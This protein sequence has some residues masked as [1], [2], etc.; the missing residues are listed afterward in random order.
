M[1]NG[2]YDKNKKPE[3]QKKAATIVS[4]I[5]KFNGLSHSATRKIL[6]YIKDGD[7]MILK[8]YKYDKELQQIEL[9]SKLILR[10]VLSVY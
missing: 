5:I 10:E 7:L 8:A 3:T 2:F 1:K 4:N 9:R 6:S